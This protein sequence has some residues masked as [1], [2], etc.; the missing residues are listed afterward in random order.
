MPRD[1]Y[2]AIV[3]AVNFFV[4]CERVF[5]PSL[6]DRPVIVLSSNDGNLISRSEEAKRLRLKMS[7]PFHECEDLIRHF[8]VA[9]RSSNF[10]LYGSFSQRI[11]SILET[12][13][14][15]V[16]QYSIDECFLEFRRPPKEGWLKL[17]KEI[18]QRILK[19]T[20]LSVRVGFGRTKT[21]AKIAQRIAKR[22]NEGIFDLTDSSQISDILTSV[23]V[24]EVWG[25]GPR[26][27]PMLHR[28]DIKTAR[29][30]RDADN[31]WLRDRLTVTGLRTALELRGISCINLDEPPPPRQ[32]IV[33]SRA[34]GRRV[35]DLE[36]ILEAAAAAATRAAARLRKQ[37][38]TARILQVFIST[39]RLAKVPQ[40]SAG[41][42]E[43][44]GRQTDFTPDLVAAAQRAA[45]RIF[46]SGYFFHRLGVMLL[47]LRPAQPGQPH[48][49]YSSLTERQRKA[50]SAVDALN[51]RFGPDT[52]RTAAEGRTDQTWRVNAAYRSPRYMTR[53]E[54]LLVV[55]E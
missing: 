39:N 29:E 37:E 1:R 45:S 13:C 42:V 7:E 36:P 52:V 35:T 51:R 16:E 30:L 26:K 23:P 38:S 3:D 43:Y 21:L 24:E 27:V 49:F 8:D 55:G 47:E 11:W 18:Q 14:A 12:F 9:V 5:D 41:T 25:I 53:W 2:F 15:D 19:F 4:S 50:Q 54:E 10:E 31:A 34:F 46:R 32:S 28:N 22:Y 20:G 6:A 44:L 33:S 48:L 40:Y 17:G